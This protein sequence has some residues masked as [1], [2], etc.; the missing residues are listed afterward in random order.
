MRGW[1]DGAGGGQRDGKVT[2]SEADAYVKML[3]GEIQVTDQTP[4]LEVDDP[5]TWVLSTATERE[6]EGLFAAAEPATPKPSR[7]PWPATCAAALAI[8]RSSTPSPRPRQVKA[9]TSR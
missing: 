7:K 6:P 3:L 8:R 4:V 1:A 9:S 5:G 2:A